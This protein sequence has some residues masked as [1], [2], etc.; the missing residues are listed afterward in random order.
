MHPTVDEECDQQKFMGEWAFS[1]LFYPHYGYSFDVTDGQFF[2]ESFLNSFQ[3][4][5]TQVWEVS[6]K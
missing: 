6:E 4:W 3:P 2:K 5:K 1:T